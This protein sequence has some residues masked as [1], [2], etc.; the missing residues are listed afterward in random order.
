MSLLSHATGRSRSRVAL[1]GAA[2]LALAPAAEAHLVTTGMGPVYDGIAHFFLSPDDVLSAVAVA[3]LA[4]MRG[5]GAG[6]CAAALLPAG[7]I[8]GGVAGATIR[9]APASNPFVAASSLLILGIL[10]AADR[11][12]PIT[13]IALLTTLL[14]VSHGLFNGAAMREAGGAA[15][16]LQ[17]GGVAFTL[18]VIGLLAAALAVSLGRPPWRIGLRVA[19]SW[20]AA[21]GL[22]LLGWALR[23]VR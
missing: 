18:A 8:L 9:L 2:A 15:S 22:L 12:L 10:V 16:M 19:G 7:W 6:R 17:L 5:P 3:L 1:I 20:T 23:P 21:I 4:G 11:P 13:V 14:A